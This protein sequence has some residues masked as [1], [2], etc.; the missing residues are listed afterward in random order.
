MPAP[1][2]KFRML[3]SSAMKTAGSVTSL[4]A[5]APDFSTVGNK[6]P[7]LHNN[8]RAKVVVYFC[9]TEEIQKVL[10]GLL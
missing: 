1:Y 8:E 3:Q 2:K 9:G 7:T 5:G 6:L 4:S 10:R